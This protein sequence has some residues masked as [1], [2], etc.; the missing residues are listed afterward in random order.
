MNFICLNG[1]ILPKKHAHLDFNN[2]AFRYGDAIVEQ[3][4]TTG[5]RVPFFDEHFSRLVRGLGVLEL[6]HTFS[7]S[8]AE[9]L[10]SI[11]LLIHRNKLYNI[12]KVTLTVWRADDD[13]F[14]S[15]KP[16]INYLIEA[17]PLVEKEFLL[18]EK[19]LTIDVFKGAYKS[20]SYLSS[21]ITNNQTFNYLS[22]RYAQINKLDTCLILNPESKVVEADEGN[23]FY[24][25]GKT[26]YTPS[27]SSGCVDGVMRRKVLE[28][29]EEK[30]YIIAETDPLPISFILEIDEIFITNDIYGIRWVGGY[31]TTKR[32][33]K[34]VCVDLVHSLNQI[35]LK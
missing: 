1:E 11:E 23:I 9:L 7:F 4:R 8:K 27:L 24:V 17:E 10:R 14:L 30:D 18:N 16:E 2:R 33:R 28:I 15:S 12:N 21:Y 5:I 22:K 6:S 3:M 31:S 25:N 13:V 35:F 26:I 20:L 19:G 29:A 32:Y 34:R